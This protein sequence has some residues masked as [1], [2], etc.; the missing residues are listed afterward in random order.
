MSS[1][2]HDLLVLTV[3]L[4]MAATPGLF[5]LRDRVEARVRERDAPPPFDLL[6]DEGNPVIIAGFG[7]FGQ[8]VA[9]ILRLRRIRFT[10]LEVS[11][12]QVD[13]VRR[14]GN[15]IFY[16]D[17]ARIELLRAAGTARAKL[18]VLAIDDME[19]SLRTARLVQRSFPGVRILA[20][21]RNRQHAYALLGLGIEDVVRETLLGKRG[22]GPSCTRG[23]GQ[24]RKA[25]PQYRGSLRSVRRGARPQ[26]VHAP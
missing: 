15:R 13:F 23:S 17:A 8:I 3:T 7:R 5:A 10:A 20:R 2:L 21:A 4:S 1:K 11:P 22:A 14:F 18:F 9:R 16:G 25:R 24:R 12:K 26:G 19:A 6:E